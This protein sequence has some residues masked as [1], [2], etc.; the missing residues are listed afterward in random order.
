ML[1]QQ[2]QSVELEFL[3]ALSF[4]FEPAAL[5]VIYGGRGAGKCL[6][7]G[8]KVIMFDGSLKKV[9]DVQINDELMGPDC[10]PRKVLGTTR[11]TDMMYKVNQTSG[12]DYVVNSAHILSLKKSE[13]CKNDIGEISKAG[14][15]RRPL[16]R[17]SSYADITNINVVEASKKSVRWMANF[18]GYKTGLICF[19]E[20]EVFIDPWYLG[21]WLGDGKNNDNIIY[22]ED[23]EV[24]AACEKYAHDLEMKISIYEGTVAGIKITRAENGYNNLRQ[25]FNHYKLFENKHIPFDYLANSENIRL[26]V[27]AGLLDTDGY[28]HNNG[29]EITQVNERLANEIKYLAD[30]LG[31]KTYLREKKTSCQNGYMGTA[32]R[33]TI[34]GDTWR[35]PC[36]IARKIVKKENVRKNKDFLLSQISIECAGEGEYAGFSLDGDKLFLL[37][38]GTVTHNT[39]G[40]AIALIV[41]SRLKRLRIACFRE[42]QRSIKESMHETIKLKIYDLE[43]IG[44][45]SPGEF[46]ITDSSIVCKRTGSEFIYAGLRYNIESIKSMARIDIGWIEEAKNVSKSSLDK[47]EPTIRGRHKDDPAGLGGPFGKGPELW[48]TFNPELDS[49]EVYR[50][51]VL[52]RSK[53]APD[54]VTN[55]KGEKERYAYVVKVNWQDNKWF[56]DDLRQKMQ[57]TKIASEDD[58]LHV[59]EGFTKVVLDG[60]IYADEIRTTIKDGRIGSVRYDENRPVFTFWDLGHSDKTAIWFIQRVAMEYN[61][62]NYF[63]DRLKKMPYYISKLQEFGYNYGKHYLP[64]DGDAETLSNVT[65]KAQLLKQ[66]P[67]MVQ[68]VERPS[69][70]FVGINAVRS[71]FPLCNFDEVNTADGMQCL[72]RYCYKVNEETGTFSKEPDHDTPYSHGADGFQ[73]FALSLKTETAAKKPKTVGVGHNGKLSNIHSST[74]WMRG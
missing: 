26:Q 44:F 28:L 69:K 56:P 32:F 16:G 17:Y 46:H 47:L 34:N 51:Y 13:S 30:T 60:A 64:H 72:Q 21:A 53:W 6:A 42:L 31:F 67:K 23:I 15:A 7:I 57:L 54:Y 48:I 20:K 1:A 10:Y 50:K 41:L 49:D 25:N 73:T 74:G 11:G 52:N 70:K 18:R 22:S 59:W 63:E 68:I 3:D 39:E 45:L 33:V 38:D 35:I 8:T 29:Y 65:P 58:Y 36:K 2:Q 14:N 12:I 71:V 19:D 40:V 24:L 37:E 61:V 27:L 9:E 4:L 55:S 5:K 43:R 66:Y 62:I